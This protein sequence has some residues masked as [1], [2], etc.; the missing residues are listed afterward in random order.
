[1]M[2]N[3]CS[4]GHLG[5]SLLCSQVKE[6]QMEVLSQSITFSIHDLYQEKE[7]TQAFVDA[8]IKIQ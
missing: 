3:S 4:G 5:L 6:L 2:V 1:M 7:R 8:N